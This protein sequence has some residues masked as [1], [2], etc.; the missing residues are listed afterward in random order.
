[1]VQTLKLFVNKLF[2]MII[3]PDSH[4]DIEQAMMNHINQSKKRIPI[5]KA[6]AKDKVNV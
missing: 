4:R 2:I 1:M 6:I 5:P 3:C